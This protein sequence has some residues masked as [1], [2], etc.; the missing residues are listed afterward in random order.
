MKESNLSLERVPSFLHLPQPVMALIER[1]AVRR[2][3]NAGEVV[4]IEG[5]AC[6]GAYFVVSGEMAVVRTSPGGREQV[7]A[8]LSPGQ[9]FNTVPPFLP[10]GRNHATVRAVTDAEL[11]AIPCPAFRRLVGANPE[12]ALCLLG[13]FA[14]RL[15]HLTDLV[16]GLSLR[17]VRGRVARFLLD[18]ADGSTLQGRF[19]QDEIAAQVGTVRDMVGRALRSF[20]DEGLLRMERHHILLFDRQGLESEAER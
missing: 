19:T 12:L 14:E 17:S 15:D 10:N 2:T 4:I 5:L 1:A 20:A 3:V 7:L 18:R 16:E 11:Y 6:V 13:D 8:L 9:A